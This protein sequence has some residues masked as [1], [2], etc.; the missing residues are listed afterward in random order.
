MYEVKLQL[1]SDVI[2]TNYFILS[3]SNGKLMLSA[4]C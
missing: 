1:R 4:T 2:I 3:N